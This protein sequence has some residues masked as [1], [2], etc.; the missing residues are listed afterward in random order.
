MYLFFSYVTSKE[1][2]HV[3]HLNVS[4]FGL[5]VCLFVSRKSHSYSDS[6]FL[7][8]AS[9]LHPFLRFRND[10]IRSNELHGV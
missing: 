1:M 3:L 6:L 7:N 10:I 9:I 5:F 2:E 8:I 4:V